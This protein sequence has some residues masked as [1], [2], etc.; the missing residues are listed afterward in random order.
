MKKVDKLFKNATVLTVDEKFNQF[1]N[2]AVAV[3]GDAIV[4]VGPQEEIC[5]QYEAAEV[6]DCHGKI[7]MPGLVNGHHQMWCLMKHAS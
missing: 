7:L 4:A 6:L 3:S 5:K 2:G 1:P